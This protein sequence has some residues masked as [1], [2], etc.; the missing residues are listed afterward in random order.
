[1]KKLSTHIIPI[2]VVLIIFPFVSINAQY[3]KLKGIVYDSARVYP[4]QA[5]SVL[6]ISGKGTMTDANGR[7]EIEVKET[8]SIWFSYL[9]KPTKKYAV[10]KIFDSQHFDIALHVN[11]PVL[12]EIILR[13]RNYRFDSLQN[14]I[15]YA[16]VFNWEKPKLNPNLGSGQLGT[17][18]GFDLQEIIRMFQFRKNKS[19]ELFQERLLQQE[20]EKFITYRF[21]KALVFRLTNLIGEERDLFM[22]RCR[23]TYEFCIAANDYEFHSYIKVCFERMKMGTITIDKQFK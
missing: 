22:N 5:V 21:N 13:P 1:M 2:L 6:T 23:P 20:R 9:N 8:D 16:K 19:M 10:A 18:V 17:A 15:D 14:R 4:L 12:K 3:F 7:Y 11:I